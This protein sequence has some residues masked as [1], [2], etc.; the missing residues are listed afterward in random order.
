MNG[1][2]L[3]SVH[4][5][6]NIVLDKNTVIAFNPETSEFEI[7]GDTQQYDDIVFTHSQISKFNALAGRLSD[8]RLPFKYHAT[9]CNQLLCRFGNRRL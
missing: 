9:R 2:F 4:L 1:T 8:L 7:A 5:A 6:S 3:L